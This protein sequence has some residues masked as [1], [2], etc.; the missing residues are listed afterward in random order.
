M[1]FISV[2][3]TY[4]N[5][6][7]SGIWGLL[8]G[9]ALGVPYEFHAS[10]ELPSLE[11]IEFT[12]P[13]FFNKTYPNVLEGTWS[14]DGAQALCLLDILIQNNRFDLDLYAKKLLSWYEKGTWTVDG[15]VFDIG[16]QTG[17]ALL[18]YRN[19]TLAE[20]AGRVN[21][22]GK[23]NGALMRVLPLALWHKGTDKELVLDAHNQCLITH[24]HLCNQVCCA[25]YCLV[26]RYLKFHGNFRETYQKALYE[27]RK[28]YKTM[29]EFEQE[30]EWSIRPDESF[31]GTG[32]GYVVDCLHSAFMILDK[33]QSYEEAV[34]QAVKLGNDTDT[35]ACVTGGLA[36]ILYGY[37]SIPKRFLDKLRGREKVEQLLETL[38]NKEK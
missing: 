3:K 20:F 6:I 15:I 28:I 17:N 7:K 22:Q 25:F 21:L 35:T 13:S 31:Y 5:K 30:F 9:D 14:D 1:I 12:P 34:K 10:E 8:I 24:S 27:I 2:E 23:G 32:S 26:A 36:G 29:P 33:S 38:N 37:E 18:A 4:F 11:D 16:I 19:G